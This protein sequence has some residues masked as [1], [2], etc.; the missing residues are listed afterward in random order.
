MATPSRP[1]TQTQHGSIIPECQPQAHLRSQQARPVGQSEGCSGQD[2]FTSNHESIQLERGECVTSVP[3]SLGMSLPV[4]LPPAWPCPLAHS[5]TFCGKCRGRAAWL[6][7]PPAAAPPGRSRTR[8][9]PW[10]A[11]HLG[12][13]QRAAV[14]HSPPSRSPSQD[15]G[16]PPATSVEAAGMGQPSSSSASKCWQEAPAEA[17]SGE[18]GLGPCRHHG[19]Q[20]PNPQL[21]HTQRECD[22]PRHQWVPGTREQTPILRTGP[23]TSPCPSRGSQWPGILRL[24]RALQDSP[25]PRDIGEQGHPRSHH[26]Q[27]LMGTLSP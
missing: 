6:S 13:E 9:H 5:G 4:P 14:R 19:R 15:G 21:R 22:N 24:L 17:Q 2:L 12:G 27:G 8:R 11:R 3:P 16:E 10:S 20:T 7:C 1:G 25:Q 26:P 23:P 18:V